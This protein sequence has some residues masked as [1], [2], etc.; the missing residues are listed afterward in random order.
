MFSH[1]GLSLRHAKE[2]RILSSI[3]K[4][5]QKTLENENLQHYHSLILNFI[6]CLY[7]TNSITGY[8]VLNAS[9]DCLTGRDAKINIHAKFQNLLWHLPGEADG[10]Q[11]NLS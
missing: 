10:R 2:S 8:T 9:N 3:C 1:T 5:Q 6:Y 11:E 4:N 7:D